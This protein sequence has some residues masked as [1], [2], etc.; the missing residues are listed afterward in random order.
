MPTQHF[1]QLRLQPLP[2]MGVLGQQVPGPAK[3]VGGCFVPG[4][5][6]GDDFVAQLLVAHAPA[7]FLILGGQQHV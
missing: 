6:D 4:G 5:E 3:G 2:H 1:V 7:G